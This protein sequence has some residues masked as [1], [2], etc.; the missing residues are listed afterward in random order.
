MLFIAP[1]RT[2]PSEMEAFNIL[3]IQTQ[4]QIQTHNANAKQTQT[5]MQI[6]TQTLEFTNKLCNVV[7]SPLFRFPSV[8]ISFFLQSFLT[9]DSI[10]N[11][12]ICRFLLLMRQDLLNAGNLAKSKRKDFC[13]VWTA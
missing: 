9:P 12:T 1:S 10:L 11:P 13:K 7:L 4:M 5:Q 6:Q 8:V 2:D 3:L